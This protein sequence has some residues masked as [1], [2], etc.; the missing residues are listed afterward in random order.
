LMPSV[1]GAQLCGIWTYGNVSP[2]GVA[3]AVGNGTTVIITGVQAFASQDG[4]PWRWNQLPVPGGVYYDVTWGHGLFVAAGGGGIVAS[5]DGV[6]WFTVMPLPAGAVEDVAWNGT[7]FVAVGEI[8][9]GPF[10]GIYSNSPVVM[11]STDGLQWATTPLPSDVALSKVRWAR[12]QWIGLSSGGGEYLN[13][14]FTSADGVSWT[15]RLPDVNPTGVAWN[16]SQYLAVGTASDNGPVVATSPDGVQWTAKPSVDHLP[17]NDVASDGRQWVVTSVLASA[18]TPYEVVL[19]SEDG[20]TWR[21][22]SFAGFG[23]VASVVRWTG[24]S[25]ITL[26]SYGYATSADGTDWTVSPVV[27]L[28]VVTWAGDHFVAV[29]STSATGQGAA[30]T[31]SDG[32]AWTAA[33]QPPDGTVSAAVWTGTQVVAVG[34]GG[35]V[36]TSPDGDAWTRRA[37]LATGSPAPAR[38]A[39]SGTQLLAAIGGS[40]F[41]SVDGANWTPAAQVDGAIAALDWGAGQFVAVGS[42]PSSS[43]GSCLAI[44][45]SPDG[46]QWVQRKGDVACTFYGDE[47]LMG[48]AWNG[49]RFVTVGLHH[50][51]HQD[52]ALIAAQSADGVSWRPVQFAFGS[53]EGSLPVNVWW[54]GAGFLETWGGRVFTSPDGV[55]WAEEVPFSQGFTPTAVAGNGRQIVAV[56]RMG[57]VENV[58]CTAPPPIGQPGVTNVA[59]VTAAQTPG[60]A[61]TQWVTD[62]ELFNPGA[63]SDPAFLYYLPRD[64]DNSAPARR[65]VMVPPGQAVRLGNVVGQLF[66]LGGSAGALTVSSPQPLLATSRTYTTSG[67]G[68]LGQFVPGLGEETALAAGD[69]AR[70]IQ[71]TRNPS[72]R[73][74]IGFESITS[75]PIS[76]TVN[77]FLATGEFL[78]T[79]T[80]SLQSFGSAQATEI[81]PQIGVNVVDDAFAVVR[82]GTPGARFFT[83]AAVV[84][85]TSGDSITVLPGEVSSGEPLYVPAVAHNPGLSG[86]QWRSDLEVHNPGAVQTQYT[87]ELLKS[88]QDNSTPASATFTLDPG[89][90]RR[91][92]DVVKDVFGFDGSGAIRVT[93]SVGRIMVAARSYTDS[94]NGTRGQF[95]PGIAASAATAA[96]VAANLIQLTQTTSGATGFRTNIGLVNA[97][98]SPISVQIDLYSAQR[99]WLGREA[100]S[101][102]PY[103]FRQETEIFRSVT[104]SDV[105]D[106]FAVVT[107]GPAGARFLAYASVVDNASGDPIYIRAVS[108]VPH[109]ASSGAGTP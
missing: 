43:T 34:S 96:D 50:P 92:V 71:L 53:Y 35:S 87:L 18:P 28:S 47:A 24:T 22:S 94:G 15:R 103:E 97:T 27:D 75:H 59:V 82:S 1:L 79:K 23:D 106:G 61:G 19:T 13:G 41:T 44:W 101:L 72:Y 25:F 10:G 40:L 51:I 108:V 39:W 95:I 102:A 62:V 86:T 45:S 85:N 52:F 20:V 5:T 30:L 93:P 76:I 63:Y 12:G 31:S 16:G 64:T 60:L 73:T 4:G 83:Y 48:V 66:G 80:F 81:F 99:T 6:A 104:F 84:D 65:S 88:G 7:Q 14:I 32:E 49:T 107:G 33:S 46:V 17:M 58:D 55:A 26:G 105:N 29:G 42:R 100:L 78:G 9:S 54:T 91:Y 89:M 2:R 57:G 77:L 3:A 37:S 90:S 98:A 8:L 38:L 67:A 36:F 21:Q 69:E 68:T 109:V 74:N 56:G 70:L 11:T